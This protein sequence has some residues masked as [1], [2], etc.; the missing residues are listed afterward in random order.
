MILIPPLGISVIVG[1][2]GEQFGVD[3]SGYIDIGN[4]SPIYFLAQGCAIHDLGDR[5]TEGV[6]AGMAFFDKIINRPIWRNSDN[7][8]D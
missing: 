8:L 4:R 2:S 3:E 7:W 1:P 6:Y 5:P